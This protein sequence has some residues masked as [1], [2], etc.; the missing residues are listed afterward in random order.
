MDKVNGELAERLKALAWKASVVLNRATVGPNPT[1]SAIF[2]TIMKKELT[3][4]DKSYIAGFLDGEGCFT[5]SGKYHKIIVAC[6]NTYLPVIELLHDVFGG[7]LTH[8][9]NKRKP[10]WRPTHRWTVV[11]QDALYVCKTIVPYLKE[12]TE[13]ALLLILIQQTK[14]C[15]GRITNEVFEERE[16]L[17]KGVK[18]LK[19]VTW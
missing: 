8:L 11:A 7:S 12:K 19:H 18:R 13:Q 1:F 14:Q 17:A 16:R 4:A 2:K 10:N 9:Q 5:L 3:E 15:N 6:E